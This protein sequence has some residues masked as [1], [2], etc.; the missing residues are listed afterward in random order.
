M[1][2]NACWRPAQAP[3][4]MAC[5]CDSIISTAWIQAE[6]RKWFVEG[7][8]VVRFS[9]LGF[10]RRDRPSQNKSGAKRDVR[11]ER[12][13]CAAFFRVYCGISNEGNGP[14][15]DR[16][17][18]KRLR[19]NGKNILLFADGTGRAATREESGR[20]GRERTRGRAAVRGR[21]PR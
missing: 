9:P 19:V 12:P 7:K 15:R 2:A 3:A 16:I 18:Y 13:A 17:R 20:K 14:L 21:L 10:K 11:V 8:G 6:N 1:T 4:S 5:F